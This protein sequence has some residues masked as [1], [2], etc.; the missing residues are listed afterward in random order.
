MLLD[1]NIEESSPILNDNASAVMEVY[2][3]FFDL[4]ELNHTIMRL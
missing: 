3:V 1:Y 2:S 4:T